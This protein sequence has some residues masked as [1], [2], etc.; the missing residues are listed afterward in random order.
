MP[1]QTQPN[2]RIEVKD[3][4]YRKLALF[5]ILGLFL[6]S[7][8]SWQEDAL[9]YQTLIQVLLSLV[10]LAWFGL[11]IFRVDE[12]KIMLLSETGTITWLQPEDDTPWEISSKSR[13]NAWLHWLVLQNPL[14]QKQQRMLIFRDSVSNSNWRHLCRVVSK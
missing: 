7:V 8:W 10:L 1:Q 6:L 14:L 4:R 3:S 12:D 13:F 2:I 9:P 11:Q 5:A